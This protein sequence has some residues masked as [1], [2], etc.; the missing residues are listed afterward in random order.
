VL[1]FAYFDF[2]SMDHEPWTMGETGIIIRS[3]N[4]ILP[5]DTPASP[6]FPAEANT[7]GLDATQRS[8][9]Y[10][11]HFNKDPLKNGWLVGAM[12]GRILN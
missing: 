2:E 11:V 10:H 7:P 3:L 6:G 9:E 8:H 12:T 1:F 5:K 4:A